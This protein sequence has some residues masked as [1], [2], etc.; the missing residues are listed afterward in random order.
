MN[1]FV[2]AGVP[3]APRSGCILLPT[4]DNKFVIYG[5]YSKEKVKKDTERGR[6]HADMFLLQTDK[7]NAT[8]Y[9]WVCVKQT[10]IQMSPRCGAS[11]VLIQPNQAFV[12]GGVY[13]DEDDDD[14]ENLCGTFYNDLFALD[15]EKLCWRTVTLSG[16]KDATS[17]VE[18]RK[19]RRR[20]QKEGGNEEESG[21]NNDSEEELKE[22][23]Q[24]R[25]TQST[26]TDDGIFTARYIFLF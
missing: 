7:N 11:A 16:K 21:Q 24:E 25:P 19:R 4:A 8:K 9:K 14:N 17:S 13:D 23:L 12:F 2:L 15:V 26:I 5:G 22:E 6:V 18:E 20:K 3:P 10:G 1:L